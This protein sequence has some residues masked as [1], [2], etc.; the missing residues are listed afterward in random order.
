VKDAPKLP[1]NLLDAIR[2]F[3]ADEEL[4]QMLGNEFSSSYVKMKMQEWTDYMTHFSQW[5]R[6]N[7]L[8]I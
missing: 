3:D 8:D 7:T 5:E 1:L 6:D 4:K 2:W